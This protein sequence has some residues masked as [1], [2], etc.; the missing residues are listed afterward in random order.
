MRKSIDS[1]LSVAGDASQA[2]KLRDKI[3][4]TAI[5]VGLILIFWA[6]FFDH[7]GWS[8]RKVLGF[9][10]LLFGA[11]VFNYKKWYQKIGSI[12]FVVG[13]ATTY[14]GYTYSKLEKYT[15]ILIGFGLMLIATGFFTY[16]PYKKY[17]LY[18]NF[19]K[20]LNISQKIGMFTSAC[21]VGI[22]L[23]A[24]AG[25]NYE[26]KGLFFLLSFG[27]MIIGITSYSYG[28]YS[29]HTKGIKNNYNM[30][31]SASSRGVIGWIIG[32]TLTLFY[33]QLY[34]YSK[35]L[36]GMISL[37]D[38]W[39]ELLRGKPA[40]QWFVYGTLYTF[41]IL[42]LGIK[43][44]IKYRHNRYQ[45]IRTTVVIFSQLALA[46][47][48]PIILESLQFNG[49]TQLI[50]GKSKWLGYDGNLISSWP[51]NYDGFTAGNLQAYTH[52]AHQPV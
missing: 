45:L 31:N 46:Y 2:L 43:F 10:I 1:N 18:G 30:F 34:W 38:P 13:L 15:F 22:L 14:I 50:D 27:L 29:G 47:F 26:P 42:F 16:D 52:E 9:S 7:K 11:G 3:S 35:P 44:M 19:G 32:I 4:I 5:I 20:N 24:W 33:I 8:I 51:L 48:L 40:D 39:S 17:S 41:V 36:S 6:I 49:T 37:F 25:I 28:S 12:L 23:S 21:G